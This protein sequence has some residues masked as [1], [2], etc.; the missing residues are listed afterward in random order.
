[1][2]N[3]LSER[4]R[5]IPSAAAQRMRLHRERQRQGF[6]CLTIALHETEIDNL[7]RRGLLKDETRNDMDAV[8][9]ALYA[10]L[11]HTLGGTW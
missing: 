10:H 3:E 6:R 9:M 1:M 7:V 5:L 11:D 2:T 4:V 8:Q